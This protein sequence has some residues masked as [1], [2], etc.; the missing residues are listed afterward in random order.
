M[1]GE[2]KFQLESWNLHYEKLNDFYNKHQHTR[3]SEG[4][5]DDKQFITWTMAQR[6]RYRRGLITPEQISLL[7]ALGFEWNVNNAQW[8]ISFD[9]LVAYKEKFGH[10]YVYQKRKEYKQLAEW[11]TAAR[12]DYNKGKMPVERMQRLEAIGFVW[13]AREGEWMERYTRL[14]KF[15]QTN[16]WSSLINESKSWKW[17]NTQRNRYK[18][19]QLTDKKIKLFNEL[20]IDWNPMENGWNARYADLLKYRAENGN[21]NVTSGSA[22]H[23]S[24]FAWITNQRSNHKRGKLPENYFI[25]LKDAG[26]IFDFA[27]VKD[28]KWNKNYEKAKIF[29]LKKGHLIVPVKEDK[30]LSFWLDSQRTVNKDALSVEQLSK[31]NALNYDWSSLEEKQDK[32][33]IQ[34]YSLL[35]AFKTECGHCNVPQGNEKHEALAHW[36]STQ[37]MIYKNG[38]IDNYR[39]QLLE[40]IGF[41]WEVEWQ[42]W[43]SN[44][45]Q[46]KKHVELKG[47]DSSI[48]NNKISKWLKSQRIRYAKG[49]LSEKEIMLLDSIR[50]SWEQKS[51]EQIFQDKWMV[52]YEMLKEYKKKNG[53]CHV[54]TGMKET[55]ILGCW[56]LTQRANNK[57]NILLPERKKLLDKL[58]FDWNLNEDFNSKRWMG[59]FKKLKAYHNEHG[60]SNVPKTYKTDHSLALWVRRQRLLKRQGLMNNERKELLDSILF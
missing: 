2:I 46:L 25:K 23:S 29:Y 14:K 13:D 48:P 57:L 49:M 39:K 28:E 12:F 9:N 51:G 35:I 56:V 30:K 3:V 7:C 10:C 11:V 60:H 19:S 16:E 59:Q 43:L 8:D 27:A 34:N 18:R 33:W 40:H 24:L 50:I 17:V 54:P 22:K 5:C 42:T 15:L 45:E 41:V 1:F 4:N 55:K 20:K 38:S 6:M 44:F 58:S 21:C 47:A 52:S 53:S 32:K 26:L 36:C 31:L 37:R